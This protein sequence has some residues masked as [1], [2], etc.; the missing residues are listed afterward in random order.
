MARRNIMRI[1]LTGPAKKRLA[2]LS[3]HHGMT[4]VSMMSYLLDWFSNQKNAIQLDIVAG[5][6]GK[7]DAEVAKGILKEMAGE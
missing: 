2:T 7:S 4:Q 1:E 5:Y 3:D 6:G